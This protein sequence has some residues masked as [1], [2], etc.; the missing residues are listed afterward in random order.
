MLCPS[1][2]TPINRKGI[3]SGAAIFLEG[4]MRA[5]AVSTRLISPTTFP[6]GFAPGKE[7]QIPTYLAIQ[8]D[9]FLH[10]GNKNSLRVFLDIV[11]LHNTLNLLY[12]LH[13]LQ[14]RI[15]QIFLN[16]KSIFNRCN[17]SLI[18]V[19]KGFSVSEK[20]CIFPLTLSIASSIIVT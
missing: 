1:N 5:E 2:P 3:K 14:K 15:R 8:P 9:P 18:G 10:P 11:Q 7:R 6:I 13:R 17:L 4:G 16:S 12:L 20:S 19:I